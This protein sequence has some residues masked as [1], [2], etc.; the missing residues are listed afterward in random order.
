MRILWQ[1]VDHPQRGED[2]FLGGA[3]PAN[4]VLV[5]ISIEELCY[6]N[7]LALRILIIVF[8]FLIGLLVT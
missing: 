8:F 5:D 6:S 3:K 7:R 4:D 1:F 2:I